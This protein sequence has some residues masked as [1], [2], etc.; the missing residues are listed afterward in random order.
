MKAKRKKLRFKFDKLQA[1][2]NPKNKSISSNT[3]LESVS[4]NTQNKQEAP[5]LF[6]KFM[7]PKD[8]EKELGL[9]IARQYVLRSSK[10]RDRN[11]KKGGVNLPFIKQM[12]LIVYDRDDVIEWLNANK[13]N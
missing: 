12:G 6:N 8:L 2:E 3:H 13:K 10:F 5:N 11:A 4:E 7:T 9:S 1:K